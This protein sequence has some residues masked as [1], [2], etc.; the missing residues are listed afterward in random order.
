[1]TKASRGTQVRLVRWSELHAMVMLAGTVLVLTVSPLWALMLLAGVSFAALVWACRTHWSPAGRFGAANALTAARLLGALALP[2]VAAI[3]PLAVAGV[4]VMLFAIDGVDGW[5]ARRLGLV[6][7]FGEYFDKETDAFFM[8]VLCLLLHTGGRF[9]AWILV[10]GLLR[11]GFVVFLMLAK[12]AALK[13]RQSARG[14]WMYFAMISALIVAFTPFPAFY[15]PY[16]LLM[17]LVLL[18]SFAH[19]LLDLYRSPRGNGSA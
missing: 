9:E 17:T 8:L 15:Q 12:P 19:A 6:S 5:L 3:S 11:Y 13:E 10:P 14:R 18:Y 2:A 7:E 4:A 16:A 1:M